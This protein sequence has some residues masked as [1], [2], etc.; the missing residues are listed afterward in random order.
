VAKKLAS[1]EFRPT[2]LEVPPSR[3]EST[4]GFWFEFELG[5]RMVEELG[6]FAKGSINPMT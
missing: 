1:E 5:R 3:V 2:K 6:S 4:K